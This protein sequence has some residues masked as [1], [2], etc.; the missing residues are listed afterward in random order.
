PSQQP[1]NH[2]THQPTQQPTQQPT[3]QPTNQP[4]QQPPAPWPHP[5]WPDSRCQQRRVIK[6]DKHIS[7]ALFVNSSCLFFC[8]TSAV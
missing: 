8:N 5:A 6:S 1:T 7:I 2:P 3:D 4:T